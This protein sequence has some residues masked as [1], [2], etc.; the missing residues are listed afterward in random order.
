MKKPLLLDE[1]HVSL[2]IGP[3]V[4]DDAVAAIR[5]A[6]LRRSF[7]IHLRRVVQQFVNSEVRAAARLHVELSR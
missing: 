3:T 5:R 4:A 1:I 2:R 7:L 6:T